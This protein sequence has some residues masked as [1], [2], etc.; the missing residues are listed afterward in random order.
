MDVHC[1]TCGEPWNTHH[2]RYYEVH[3][4]PAGLDWVKFRLDREDWDKQMYQFAGLSR[5]AALRACGPGPTPPTHE[6]WKG[7][8]T[9]F[10]R[11]QFKQRGWEFGTSVVAVLRCPCCPSEGI[12]R[13][14]VREAEELANAAER[15]ANTQLLSELLDGDEDGQISDSAL[16]LACASPEVG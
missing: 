8:L 10:W 7:K 4:T 11:E 16:A 6:A 5:K 9:D 13:K 3:E 2:L 1:A 15:R 12:L 14:K